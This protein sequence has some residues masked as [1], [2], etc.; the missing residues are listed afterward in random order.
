MF[1]GSGLTKVPALPA[2][3][4][5]DYCYQ[6]MFTNCQSLTTVPNDLLPATQL[7]YACYHY[8]F[9]QCSSLTEAPALP[10]TGLADFCCQYM[11]AECTN[12]ATVHKLP[13]TTLATSCYSYMFYNCVSLETVP[14]DLLPATTLSNGCYNTMFRGCTNLTTA[15]ELPAF[16]LV[17]LC[18]SNMFRGC[19]NLNSVTC[20]ATSGIN[21]NQSTSNWM[22]SVAATGT[23]NKASGVTW[24]TGP[25]GIPSGWITY[26]FS[27]SATQAVQFAPGNL[28]YKSGEG[29]RFAEHQYD[30]I[31]AW[32]ATDWVD[33]FGWGT[34][35]E[36]KNPLLTSTDNADYQWSTDFQGT[37]NGHND[38]YTLSIDEWIY[39]FQTRTNASSLYG[40][41]TVNGVNGIILLRDGSTLSINT[42]HNSWSNNTIDATTWANTYEVDG[43]VFLPGAGRRSGTGV[44][45]IGAGVCWSS[46]PHSTD[47]QRAYDILYNN[48]ALSVGDVSRRY[49]GYSVRLAR[50][51]QQ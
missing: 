33:Y 22:N 51:V 38:W 26:K 47:S 49:F 37:L 41:G 10:A 21:E 27:V 45:Y 39:L 17:Y 42:D 9:Y 43:A 12:L 8:M 35:G 5:A 46:T 25:S 48:G 44:G 15:P 18:Y 23:F 6:N 13:A 31:G 19:L 14:D 36:G 3:Q 2:T 29:W 16:E 4:L 11:F 34:W 32:D 30:Y 50:I 20:L 40:M 7:A 28:Q 1:Q 24:P